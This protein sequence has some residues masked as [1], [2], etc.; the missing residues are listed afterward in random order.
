MTWARVSVVVLVWV[1]VVILAKLRFVSSPAPVPHDVTAPEPQAPRQERSATAEQAEMT[2]SL[3]QLP[4]PAA[5]K[6]PATPVQRIPKNEERGKTTPRSTVSSAPPRAGGVEAGDFPPI[7]A[8]YDDIGFRPYLQ[9]AV[10]EAKAGVFVGDTNR[11][12]LVAEVDPVTGVL[13]PV[14]SLDG[15][16][17]RRPRRLRDA[18]AEPFLQQARDEFGPG[19]Y[20]LFLFFPERTEHRLIRI[21]SEHLSAKRVA[22]A[23]V[24]H[25]RGLYRLQNGHLT[26]VITEATEKGGRS[27]S[28]TL[29]VDLS[30][31][32]HAG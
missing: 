4:P 28:L 18:A 17:A 31:D 19:A 26:L 20:E 24:T 2:V 12:T 9:A 29:S 5:E 3:L 6:P 13:H 15:L 8:D 14:R 1:V 11:Q 16:A 25:L 32:D 7:I 30:S 22:V 21:L 10:R 23:D 27:I